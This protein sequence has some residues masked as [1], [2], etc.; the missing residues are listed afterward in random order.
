MGYVSA[1]M[2]IQTA[3]ENADICF[4]DNDTGGG[5]GGKV[6]RAEKGR[7]TRPAAAN[8]SPMR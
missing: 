8:F 1:P 2:R 6:K 5:I 4:L 3:F 7:M